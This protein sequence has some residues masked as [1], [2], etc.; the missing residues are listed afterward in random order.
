MKQ[1]IFISS[2]QKELAEERVAIR[3]FVRSDPL[4]GRFFDVFLF[5]E[6][7]ATDQRADEVYLDKVDASDIYLGLF[8]DEYG[9]EDTEGRSPTEA[10]FR[11]ATQQGKTRL[12]FVKGGD[13]RTKHPKMQALIQEAGNQLIIIDIRGSLQ[14]GAGLGGCLHPERID[15]E[16]LDEVL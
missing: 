9:H 16:D 13:D 10:E 5:E 15:L 6:L 12:V 2:V 4:L 11:R 8:A 14:V 7:P 1:T 3:D